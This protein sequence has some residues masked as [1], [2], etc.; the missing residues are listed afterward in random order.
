MLIYKK[1]RE[2]AIGEGAGVRERNRKGEQERPEGWREGERERERPS[3]QVGAD[4]GLRAWKER[5][6]IEEG[7][8][9]KERSRW[10]TIGQRRLV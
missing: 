10:R 1:S 6:E 9:G 7:L 4:W 8:R 3:E 2:A 5:L